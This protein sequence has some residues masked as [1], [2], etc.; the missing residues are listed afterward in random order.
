MQPGCFLAPFSRLRLRGLPYPHPLPLPPP[1]AAT[2]CA[3]LTPRPLSS[4][5]SPP[6]L[7]LHSPFTTAGGRW[8]R[9]RRLLYG[10]LFPQHAALSGTLRGRHDAYLR[11]RLCTAVLLQEVALVCSTHQTPADRRTLCVLSLNW[12][13][14]YLSC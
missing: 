3:T 7:S 10:C 9:K 4:L 5:L 11:N 14:V 8:K 6:Q 12:L 2:C 1:P 13:R